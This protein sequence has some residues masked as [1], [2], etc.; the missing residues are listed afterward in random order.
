[1]G[2]DTNILCLFRMTRITVV[3]MSLPEVFNSNNDDICVFY[4]IAAVRDDVEPNDNMVL[5]VLE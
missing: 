5:C 4:L 3:T 2:W 1:M